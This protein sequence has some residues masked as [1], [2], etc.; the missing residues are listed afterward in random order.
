[1]PCDPLSCSQIVGT[2]SSA[3]RKDDSHLFTSLGACQL[4]MQKDQ[5]QQEK[6][7][8]AQ[9]IFVF[10]KG[11]HT[12]KRP[13]EDS[14]DETAE[15][16]LGGFSR[17]RVRSSSVTLHTTDSHSPGV[18]A[19][20]QMR[21]RS[22]SFTD[23]PAFPPSG[24]VRKNNVF[25]TS[26]LVQRNIDINSVEQGPVRPSEHVLRPAILQLP[27]A[28]SCENISKTSGHGA[29]KS[30]KIKG[31]TKHKISELNSSLRS[32]NLPRARCSVQ[33]SAD[34]SEA[35]SGCQ[36]KEDK[37]S[38]K[39]CSSDF[40]FGENMVE[41][42]LGT[43]KL[44]QPPLQNHSYAKEK[45]FRSVLKFPDTASEPSSIKNISLIESAA[46][47]SS[48]PSQKCLLEK[49]DVVTGEEM[50]HNVLKINCKIFVFTKITQSWTERGRGLLRL[51]DIA[52]SDC[53][54]L[55][56][57]LIMRNQGSLRL[58]LNS[59][60]WTQMKIQRA[61][62]KN[63]RITATDLE[64]D[65]IKVFLIQ[66]SAKD[67]GYL[68]AAIHHRLVALRSLRKQADGDSA[69]SQSDT[70]LQQLSSDEDED[71]FIQ[72]SKNGSALQGSYCFIDEE[73]DS[74]RLSNQSKG[75][76]SKIHIKAGT[77]TAQTLHYTTADEFTKGNEVGA[78]SERKNARRGNVGSYIAEM[79]LGRTQDGK[80]SGGRNAIRGWCADKQQPN[81]STNR[82]QSVLPI[83]KPFKDCMVSS[84][85]QSGHLGSTSSLGIKPRKLHLLVQGRCP[86]L[87]PQLACR[88]WIKFTQD[89]PRTRK[90]GNN[91]GSEVKMLRDLA[92]PPEAQNSTRTPKP[93]QTGSSWISSG[94]SNAE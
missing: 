80:L 54:S 88:H 23:V 55:Q 69:E 68:Y 50:E 30:Y 78:A 40:V 20:S 64:D 34:T 22:S 60:L 43:Q 37:C 11:K 27:Q 89:K 57:R 21:L 12:F 10:E 31:N 26:S 3:Q 33:L 92:F 65:G 4:N 90:P 2:M 48:K 45:T 18:T 74:E 87:L 93:L 24:P 38:F 36:P 94:S 25:M 77:C 44:T 47:F 8:I 14:L 83:T 16:E 70:V 46:A 9:P 19:L 71:D 5:Q 13:A 84:E 52:S 61:N 42:V 82:A 85:F 81:S 51:N 73:I 75:S 15:R 67:I 76:H 72:I 28:Q 63:L 35:T 29:S 79:G 59:R 58:I 41:R 1:M 56:S 32:E 6:Y 49:I 17:K 7:V 53:G 66:A 86:H 62:H 91:E 39:S